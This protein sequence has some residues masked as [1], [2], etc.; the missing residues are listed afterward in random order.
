M[1]GKV[2]SLSHQENVSR[3]KKNHVGKLVASNYFCFH[4]TICPRILDQFY[5]VSYCIDWVKTSWTDSIYIIKQHYDF[6]TASDNIKISRIA[7]VV[8]Y[9]NRLLGASEITA[10]LNCYSVHLYWK[11]CVICSIYL[12]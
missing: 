8:G 5:T 2:L 10:N 4:T 12:G 1:Q 3:L 9:I 6:F 11:G 7:H